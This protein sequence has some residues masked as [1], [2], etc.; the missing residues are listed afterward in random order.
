M[1]HYNVQFK[2]AIPERS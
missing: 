2:S 1:T